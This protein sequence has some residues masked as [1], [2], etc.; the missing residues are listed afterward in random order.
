MNRK[1]SI[2]PDGELLK[3]GFIIPKKDSPI[4]NC[5][6]KL[7]Q[8]SPV[9]YVNDL[10]VEERITESK[11][12]ILKTSKLNNLKFK[13]NYTP[14][15]E[16][17]ING[18]T[19]ELISLLLEHGYLKVIENIG[20]PTDIKNIQ[21]VLEILVTQP[22]TKLSL[23]EAAKI[24]C[25]S[26]SNFSRTFKQLIGYSY[27][28]YCNIMRVQHA[29]ELL[30]GSDLSVTEIAQKLN[31]GSINYFNRVFKKFNGNTPM[32]YRKKFRHEN[33]LKPPSL[34]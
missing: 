29:E 13:L 19:M 25:M 26:Y 28:D 6:K 10:D 30:I 23:E 27:V 3:N 34:I 24:A 32:Q 15:I 12:K 2:L 16:W 7:S 31:F 18:L 22:E 17:K 33:I 8:V 21:P 11:N 4:E 1:T 5:L 20:D 14:Y 9:N